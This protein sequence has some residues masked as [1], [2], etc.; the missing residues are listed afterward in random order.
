MK[1]E[2][3]LLLADE[4]AYAATPPPA[5]L[6]SAIGAPVDVDAELLAVAGDAGRAA[7]VLD[8]EDLARQLVERYASSIGRSP[9]PLLRAFDWARWDL[10]AEAL[11]GM[12]IPVLLRAIAARVLQEAA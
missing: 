10:R 8:A 1:R 5:G 7:Y 12:R 11:E 4:L 3:L 6:A 9:A 2:F